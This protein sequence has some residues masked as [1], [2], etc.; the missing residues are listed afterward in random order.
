[1]T[2]HRMDMAGRPAETVGPFEGRMIR[3]LSDRGVGGPAPFLRQRFEVG[4]VTGAE[5][6]RITA[7]GLYIAFLNGVRVGADLLTPGWS[8]YDKRL[9]FQTYPVADLLRPG[10]T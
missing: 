9:P 1:M 4:T 10:R 5:I 8:A 6:L 2:D 3:P 7:Y